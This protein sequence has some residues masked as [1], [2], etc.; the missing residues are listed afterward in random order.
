MGRLGIQQDKI[1]DF[2]KRIITL[3]NIEIEAIFTHFAIAD[4]KDKTYTEYQFKKFTEVLNNL[5]KEG[6]RIPLRHVGNSAT[7]LDLLHMWLDMLRPGIIIYG[8]YPSKEVKKTIK[9]IPVQQFRTRIVFIKELSF[10]ESISYGRTYVT[11]TK[12]I[13]ATLPVG[14]ADGYSRLLSNQG[15]VLVRGRRFPIIGRV[16]MDQCIIDVTNL[17]QAEIVDEVV[18]WGSQGEE[19]ITVEEIA[20]K[21]KTINYEVV[22]MPDK[23]RVPKVF[24]KNG[25]PWKIKSMFGEV[26]L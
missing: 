5:K 3:K 9:L 4:E 8:L 18:L 13:V 1:I 2:A 20:E 12:T 19:M 11:A 25:K 24:F 6:I 14:Y 22:Q 21:I 26:L 15:E 16:C 10:G 23:K 7:V 17:P